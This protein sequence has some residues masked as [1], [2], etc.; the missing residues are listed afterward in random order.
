MNDI[1][2]CIV[3]Y[4]DQLSVIIIFATFVVG[5]IY[6]IITYGLWKEANF[7]SQL[8][9]S[10]TILFEIEKDAFYLNNIG[11]SPAIDIEMEDFFIKEIGL[12]EKKIHRLSFENINSLEAK[13]K[14]KLNYTNFTN[15]QQ[16]DNDV[17][18]YIHPEYQKENNFIFTLTYRNYLGIQYFTMFQTGKDGIKILKINRMTLYNKLRLFLE[19]KY[20]EFKF[21]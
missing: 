2:E 14:I 11:N 8:A 19:T 4:P 13:C 5:V 15:G 10:P 6:S 1:I 21:K 12:S 9:I 20:E 18:P 3:N 16:T 17:F 7:Q